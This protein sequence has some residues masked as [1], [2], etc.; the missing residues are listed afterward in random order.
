M[1]VEMTGTC[2]RGDVA[3]K[4]FDSDLKWRNFNYFSIKGLNMVLICISPWCFSSK[5]PISG[6]SGFGYK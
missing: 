6:V 5:H 3:V 2:T 1:G 4:M